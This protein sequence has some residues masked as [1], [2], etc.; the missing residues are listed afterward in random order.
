MERTDG[1]HEGERY[2]FDFGECSSM[3][4]FAQIDTN[5]DASY[6]GN[7]I[8][9]AERKIVTFAEGDLSF[10]VFDDDA[11]MVE[12]IQRF[13]SHIAFGFLGIDPGLGESL[14]V[15]CIAHG[16]GPFLY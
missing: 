13:K 5:Q 3:N 6:Y 1:Y 14:R 4:G 8:N 7:W 12:W 9:P 11:E 16:L 15:A 10:L 2:D